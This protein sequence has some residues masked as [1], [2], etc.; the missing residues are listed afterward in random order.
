MFT[1]NACCLVR[2]SHRGYLNTLNTCINTEL[3][4][5]CHEFFAKILN[6][7]ICFLSSIPLYGF[8]DTIK[9]KL[10]CF[11]H[12]IHRMIFFLF[13]VIFMDEIWFRTRQL[14]T[15]L[16]CWLVGYFCIASLHSVWRSRNCHMWFSL[17]T[18]A[19]G[20]YYTLFQILIWFSSSP[21]SYAVFIFIS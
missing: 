19:M 7:G 5:I 18:V 16:H 2:P 20:V 14:K 9:T 1:K 12:K 13:S 17:W 15:E 6:F 3:F 8:Y 21:F 11:P 4:D 10:F